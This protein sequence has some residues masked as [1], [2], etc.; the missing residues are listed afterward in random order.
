MADTR[1]S[2]KDTAIFLDILEFIKLLQLDRKNCMDIIL[3]DN[4]PSV[5]HS[6]GPKSTIT[7]G[8]ATTR[9]E[10]E[11]GSRSWIRKYRKH[12]TTRVT[13]QALIRLKI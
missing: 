4:E 3:R 8:G 5:F 12:W 13:L 1:T 9:Q 10:T 2:T 11:V 7:F 6:V